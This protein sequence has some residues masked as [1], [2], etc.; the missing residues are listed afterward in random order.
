M[1][2]VVA[3]SRPLRLSNQ[4]S[5]ACTSKKTQVRFAVTPGRNV[6]SK[7]SL[8][9]TIE[10]SALMRKIPNKFTSIPHVQNEEEHETV[11]VEKLFVVDDFVWHELSE[12]LVDS[13]QSRDGMNRDYERS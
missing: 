9:R 4:L 10:M 6:R 1:F 13:V 7:R 5:L 8:Y 2:V 11:S 3:L 12:R